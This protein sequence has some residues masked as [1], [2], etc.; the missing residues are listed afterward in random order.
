LYTTVDFVRIS[1]VLSNTLWVFVG[2]KSMEE[3]LRYLD[4]LGASTVLKIPL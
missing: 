3:L 1:V 2:E 4:F